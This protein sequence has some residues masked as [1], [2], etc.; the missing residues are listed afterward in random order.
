M[1]TPSMTSSKLHGL[2][3][4]SS[5][6]IQLRLYT[7]EMAIDTVDVLHSAVI[8]TRRNRIKLL[9]VHCHHA[10]ATATLFHCSVNAIGD[11]SAMQTSNII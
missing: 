5:S 4:Y 2:R 10:Q 9:H 3:P 6:A 1:L 8:I 11:V 7:V